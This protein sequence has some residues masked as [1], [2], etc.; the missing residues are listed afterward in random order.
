MLIPDQVLR[1]F[2]VGALA[3][4]HGC[5]ALPSGVSANADGRLPYAVDQAYDAALDERVAAWTNAGKPGPNHNYLENV[6][7]EFKATVRFRSS[8]EAPWMESTGTV[9]RMWVLDK[10]YVQ[11]IVEAG[12]GANSFRGMGF[13]GYNNVDGHYEVAWM[14]SHSTGIQREIA[15][16]DP[17]K[18]VMTTRSSYRDPVSSRYVHSWGTWDMSN[19][20]KHMFS[21]FS[22]ALDG[23]EFKSFE[24]L[25]ER[26]KK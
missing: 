8:P 14:D 15:T 4:L 13:L 9:K 24:G 7:G 17:D 6:I 16:F 26:V 19:P 1:W 3:V 11:E 25:L 18:K 10:R 12:S 21:G 20:D 2:A 5:E 22:V 23:R